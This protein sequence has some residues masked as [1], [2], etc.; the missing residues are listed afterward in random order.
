L[1]FRAN[2]MNRARKITPETS[3]GKSGS[4]RW[5]HGKMGEIACCEKHN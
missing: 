1:Y 5:G 2:K 3:G 4:G